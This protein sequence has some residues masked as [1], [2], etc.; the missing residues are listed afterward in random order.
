MEEH[1]KT[2][3]NYNLPVKCCVEDCSVEVDKG[4][5]INV[6]MKECHTDLE[7]YSCPDH[8]DK[9]YSKKGVKHHIYYMHT[10]KDKVCPICGKTMKNEF[11]VRFFSGL[12][13]NCTVL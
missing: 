1:G 12:L 3:K 7:K 11:S 13:E 2:L 10:R 9:L 4:S 6:H 5:E 8:P